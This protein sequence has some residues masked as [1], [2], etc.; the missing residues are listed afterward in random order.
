MYSTC[1]HEQLY[2]IV[3]IFLDP[4]E[5]SSFFVTSRRDISSLQL[6]WAPNPLLSPFNN[7]FNYTVKYAFVQTPTVVSQLINHL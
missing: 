6:R 7:D 5:V 1:N 2:I 3:L 4:G